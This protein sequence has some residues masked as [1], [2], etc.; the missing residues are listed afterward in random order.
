MRTK[1]ESITD[2]DPS[3]QDEEKQDDMLIRL[4]ADK[5]CRILL[6]ATLD[7]PKSAMVLSAE[8]S[9]PISTVYRRLTELEQAGLLNTTGKISNDGKYFLYKSRIK[10]IN[11]LFSSGSLKIK[12]TLNKN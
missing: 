5:Y 12:L 1:F 9:I 11:A 6:T 8:C 2:K 7:E 3:K 4:I 10:E